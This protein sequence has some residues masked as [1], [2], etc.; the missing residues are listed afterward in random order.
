MKFLNWI[1]N[2]IAACVA[3]VAVTVAVI[4][5]GSLVL[6]SYT[7]Y[8]EYEEQYYKDNL[9]A[10]V[11]TFP[12]P[13]DI[14]IDDDFAVYN[15][16]GSVQLTKSTYGKSFTLFANDVTYKSEDDQ[17]D[18]LMSDGEGV[19]DK[20]LG[21]MNED[22]GL[23]TID[24]SLSR[25]AFLDFDIILASSMQGEEETEIVETKDL[26]NYIVLKI[27]DVKLSSPEIHLGVD[28]LGINWHHLVFESVALKK[29]N[30]QITIESEG[31]NPNHNT[32][33]V[34][35]LFRNITFYSDATISAAQ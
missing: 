26:F 28:K 33:K 10:K 9:N 18:K 6:S 21:G 29:G 1:K 8:L 35:P 5:G 15:K 27:N 14:L 13:T 19:L 3:I 16:D 25:H 22:G 32:Y 11:S 31:T 24:F 23:I 20:Y 7:S 4:V 2:H 34:M 12:A 17:T 30:N